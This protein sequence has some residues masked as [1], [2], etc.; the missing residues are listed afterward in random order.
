MING[1]IITG[2]WGS[3]PAASSAAYTLIDGASVGPV[4][5]H[6]SAQKSSYQAFS[7]ANLTA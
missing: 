2:G 3:R 1:K 7:A 5:T 6:G 4:N